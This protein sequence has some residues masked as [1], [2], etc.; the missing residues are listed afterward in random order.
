MVTAPEQP[1]SA[2]A[3]TMAIHPRKR[4]EG[5]MGDLPIGIRE[6]IRGGRCTEQYDIA[7]ETYISPPSTWAASTS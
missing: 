3:A 7:T 6:L 1:A 2:A 4:D 5:L